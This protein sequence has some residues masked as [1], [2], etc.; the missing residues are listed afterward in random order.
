[1]ESPPKICHLY[2]DRAMRLKGVSRSLLKV[3]VENGV[4]NGA[5]IAWLE[6]SSI[7]YP[8]IEAYRR[9]GFDFSGL[10][11]AF[12]HGTGSSEEVALFMH[13]IIRCTCCQVL[14]S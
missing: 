3:A 9:L 12:Y 6:V 8:A 11:L 4:N 13:K 10:N 14:A 2:V 7:N 1:M 5:N